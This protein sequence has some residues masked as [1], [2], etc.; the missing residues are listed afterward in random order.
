MHSKMVA[1]LQLEN[2]CYDFADHFEFLFEHPE[3]VNN[4]LI[5]CT[6]IAFRLVADSRYEI[7]LH[8]PTIRE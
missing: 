1:L 6:K 2:V 8:A 3:C 7:A 5:S 4:L